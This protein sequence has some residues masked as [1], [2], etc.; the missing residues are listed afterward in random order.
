MRRRGLGQATNGVTLLP[1]LSAYAWLRMAD[2]VRWHSG[3]LARQ[4]GTQA[5][6][7]SAILAGRAIFRFGRT[8]CAVTVLVPTAATMNQAAK[9]GCC[10]AAW[11]VPGRVGQVAC[12]RHHRACRR[13]GHRDPPAGHAC[14]AQADQSAR[15]RPAAQGPRAGR[16]GG[17]TGIPGMAPFSYPPTRPKGCSGAR[18]GARRDTGPAACACAQTL[19]AVGAQL[20]LQ[21]LNFSLD[22]S[23]RQP[24][25]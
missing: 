20:K 3:V 1:S 16:D 14:G 11:R 24:K 5:R 25:S 12:E 10:Q 23:R 13:R 2:A 18:G 17:R 21:N 7:G 15:A 4:T 19:A 22:N 9:S 8:L 6:M